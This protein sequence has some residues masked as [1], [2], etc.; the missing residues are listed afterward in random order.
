MDVLEIYGYYYLGLVGIL[1][2]IGLSD[3]FIKVFVFF[4]PIFCIFNFFLL[5]R[6]FPRS[7]LYSS[8]I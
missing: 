2:L 4:V 8:S 6:I 1:L 5:V 3:Y 7:R